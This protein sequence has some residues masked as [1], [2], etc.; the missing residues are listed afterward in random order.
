MG[1]SPFGKIIPSLSMRLNECFYDCFYD[2]GGT[3][4]IGKGFQIEDCRKN[5]GGRKEQE[6]TLLFCRQ[7]AGRKGG[8]FSVSPW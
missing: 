7:G 6:R 2:G 5:S 8:D 3:A 1:D 4:A